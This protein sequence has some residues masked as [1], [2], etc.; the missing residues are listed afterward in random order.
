MRTAD[1]FLT[2]QSSLS[3]NRSRSL[4]A[5]L[6]IVIG[7]TS[8]MLIV[9]ISSGAQGL[10][11]DQI[12][13]L[14]SSVLFIEPGREPSGPS[15][16]TELFTDSLGVEDVQSLT[17][18]GNIP[19]IKDVS[20]IA[21]GSFSVSWRNEAT[22]ASTIGATDLVAD[23]L[24][25][26]PEQGIFFS[27]EEVKRRAQVAVVGSEVTKKLFGGSDAVGQI[28][29]IKNV[30]FRVVGTL[31]EKGS[32]G[33]FNI[34][35]SVL[36]P[37][38]TM[39]QYLTGTDYFQNILV[40]VESEDI[41]PRVKVD[42]AALLRANHNISDPEKDDFHIMTPQD[43]AARV[44]AI[45]GILQVLLSAVAAIS[46]IVGGIG[47]MNIMIV[48]VTER[49]HEIGLR[50]ALGAQDSDILKQFLLEAVLLTT[51]GGVVG[52]ILSTILGLVAS[53][54]LSRVLGVVWTFTF[55]V[56]AMVVGLTVAAGAGLLFGI[57]PAQR[58]AKLEPVE[59]L[60]YE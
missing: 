38:T 33:F 4:L 25:V 37:Y 2:A 44:S 35:S 47:I 3:A 56:G 58:A 30:N 36:V 23:I 39:Q 46:L 29:R 6:G 43:A 26:V 1:L 41:I 51:I 22:R 54:A 18:R 50:K 45:T 16:F 32:L 34:D 59:A 60:R 12:R 40:R 48:S 17:R 42:I 5:I 19:G 21:I 28:I 53:V 52:I 8:V 20:P 11:L 7:I 13:G 10:I 49:T 57:Y 24:E 14:G 55:P 27:D 15:S 31:P 9:A